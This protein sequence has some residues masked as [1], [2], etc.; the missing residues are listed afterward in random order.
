MKRVRLAD[1][2]DG[3]LGDVA[4]TL[5]DFEIEADLVDL[6]EVVWSDPPDREEAGSPNILGALDDWFQG[7][8]FGLTIILGANA[9]N[10]RSEQTLAG[11][12]NDE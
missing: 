6:G 2:P 1:Y 7:R 10:H 4:P 3:T 8:R 9:G 5:L 11:T 12:E